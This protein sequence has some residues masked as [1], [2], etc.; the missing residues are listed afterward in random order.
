MKFRKYVL[1]SREMITL[2]QLENKQ[3]KTIEN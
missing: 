1:S 2:E 3:H